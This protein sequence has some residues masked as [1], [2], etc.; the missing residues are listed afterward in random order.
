M[1]KKQ[2]QMFSFENFVVYQNMLLT[3]DKFLHAMYFSYSAS[4]HTDSGCLKSLFRYRKWFPYDLCGWG[5]KTERFVFDLLEIQYV[6]SS[7]LLF[8]LKNPSPGDS[9]PQ[10]ELVVSYLNILPYVQRTTVVAWWFH[11][12][13]STINL[14]TKNIIASRGPPLNTLQQFPVIHIKTFQNKALYGNW[15]EKCYDPKHFQ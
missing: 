13:P 10:W 7:F 14:T 15:S 1:R 12:P 6:S 3:I 8:L 9:C 2:E 4:I 11:P 5:N